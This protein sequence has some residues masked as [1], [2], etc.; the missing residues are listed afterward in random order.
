[1]GSY[2]HPGAPEQDVWKIIG[3]THQSAAL[4]S[5]RSLA[6]AIIIHR[7]LLSPVSRP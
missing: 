4:G 1:M 5:I 7:R 6:K 3:D 2:G